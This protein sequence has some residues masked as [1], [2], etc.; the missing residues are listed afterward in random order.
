MRGDAFRGFVHFRLRGGGVLLRGGEGLRLRVGVRL[1]CGG[2]LFDSRHFVARRVRFR[3]KSLRRRGQFRRLA[4]LRDRFADFRGGFRQ[5]LLR[6]P[7][8]R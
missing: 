2:V 5:R 1:L 6:V 8:R 7:F 3:L 4:R